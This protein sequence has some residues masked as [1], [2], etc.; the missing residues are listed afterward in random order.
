MSTNNKQQGFRDSAHTAT[1]T[2]FLTNRMAPPAP[3]ETHLSPETEQPPQL[4][5]SS[6]SSLRMFFGV[7]GLWICLFLSAL[8]TTIVATALRTISDDLHCLAQSNWVVL[9]YLITY[10]GFLLLFSKFTDIFGRK[11]LLV[12]AQ[13]I[14]LISSMACGAAIIFRALQGLG[15]SGIY[16]T[17]FI[18]I[19]KI[20]TV[21]KVGMYTGI[22]SSVFALASLLGPILGGTIVDN[23]TWRWV[24]FING[25]GIIFSLALVIPAIPGVNHRLLTKGQ[26]QRVDVIG[27][28]LSFSWPTMLIFALQE[29]GDGYE[30][31]SSAIIGTLVGG[32]VGL[33]AFIAYEAPKIASQLS[34]SYPQVQVTYNFQTPSE[35]ADIYVQNRI[36]H[37]FMLLCSHNPPP[38]TFSVCQWA[39]SL[40]C[41]S[42]YAY[43]YP[44]IAVVLYGMRRSIVQETVSRTRSAIH[45]GSLECSS[46]KQIADVLGSSAAI[47]GPGNLEALRV[48]QAYGA[49]YNTQFRALLSFKGLG[50]VTALV[51]CSTG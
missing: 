31:D 9:A 49:S 28:L 46:P 13:I 2:C 23:T 51:L 44:S 39:F 42:K 45:R 38:S 6:A 48:R 47:G 20:A 10:N 41:R 50:V 11:T 21:E 7:L 15:G 27:G 19:A 43:L 3:P 37:G 26:I 4:N 1:K 17:V 34:V 12:V 35:K 32:G 16:S 14:F 22:L 25:P 29:A 8:E 5:S 36:R 30:W 33:I 18:I 40:G 24:F